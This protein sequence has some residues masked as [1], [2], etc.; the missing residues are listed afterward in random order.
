MMCRSC[1]NL[2]QTVCN[3]FLKVNAQQTQTQP[4]P[5][6]MMEWN[7]KLVML[8]RAAKCVASQ[9]RTTSHLTLKN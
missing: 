4:L 7:A 8:Q 1:T 9:S 3:M 6:L 2:T 5:K